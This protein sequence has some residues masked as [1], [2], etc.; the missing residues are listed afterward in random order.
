MDNWKINKY[1]GQYSRYSEEVDKWIVGTPKPG[2]TI[3]VS[4]T[5]SYEYPTIDKTEKVSGGVWNVNASW[6]FNNDGSVNI[7][8][9]REFNRT[10]FSVATATMA[11]RVNDYITQNP[12]P[13]QDAYRSAIVNSTP[14]DVSQTRDGELV[15]TGGI[16]SQIENS[17]TTIYRPLDL[18]SS[19][20]LEEQFNRYVENEG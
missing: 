14:R 5:I 10:M 13:I 11:E 4:N 16:L 19:L 8:D 17:N 15:L 3:E 20:S 18:D 2:D 12:V 7:E 6:G 9:V 1:D